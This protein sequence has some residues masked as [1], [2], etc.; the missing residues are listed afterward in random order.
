MI[1]LMTPRRRLKW[2]NEGF[3]LGLRISMWVK[4]KIRGVRRRLYVNKIIR[5]G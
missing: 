3:P 4:C 2:I 5:K 1:D